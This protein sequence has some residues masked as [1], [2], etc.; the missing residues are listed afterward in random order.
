MGHRADA[1]RGPGIGGDG[2]RFDDALFRLF[3]GALFA[4]NALRDGRHR[5]EIK[6]AEIVETV[7]VAR[8]A[9]RGL[10]RRHPTRGA[11]QRSNGEPSQQPHRSPSPSPLTR[12]VCQFLNN[13][14]S[15]QHPSP[16]ARP[17]TASLA[18]MIPA[19]PHRSRAM[20]FEFVT[21][22][23]FTERRFGG[24]PLAVFPRAEGLGGAEM[25]AIANE[26]N[27]SETTFVLPAKDP[28]HSAE[29]RI[30]TPRY[31]MPFAGHPNVGTAFVLARAG[32]SY[33]RAIESD[34]VV[35]EEKAG[36]VPI[37]ILTDGATVVGARLASPQRLTVGP[38]I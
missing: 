17:K 9:A 35:F 12:S 33:G 38:E 30:F 32:T 25:Q 37:A 18:S 2:R 19:R 7:V 31:E 34:R 1:E 4:D 28:A 22:D 11:D 21:V 10:R 8:S 36:L 24:N 20:E 5:A 23:V 13:S 14:S 3:G 27:L 6:R 29:V 15:F 26:F 16:A